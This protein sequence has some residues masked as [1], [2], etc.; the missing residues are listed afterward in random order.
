MLVLVTPVYNPAFYYAPEEFEQKTGVHINIPSVV[1]Q[2][3]LYIIARSGSDQSVFNECRQEC[4]PEL[5]EHKL[6]LQSTIFF[7]AMALL[8]NTKEGTNKEAFS[9]A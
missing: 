4:L 9:A 8:S 2:P 3:D 5:I 7:M 1:E 6:V